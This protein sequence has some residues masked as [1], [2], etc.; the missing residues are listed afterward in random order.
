MPSDF[1]LRCESYRLIMDDTDDPLLSVQDELDR[2]RSLMTAAYMA[3]ADV[4]P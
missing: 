3:A 4:S 2:T 1:E